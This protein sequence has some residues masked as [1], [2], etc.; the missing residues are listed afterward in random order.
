MNQQI[1]EAL[2]GRNVPMT[3]IDE[4]MT[5]LNRLEKLEQAA[6]WVARDAR[7]RAPEAMS[8]EIVKVYVARLQ[9]ALKP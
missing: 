2:I 9:E 5:K 3:M 4:I 1:E 7:Y 6:G 8:L